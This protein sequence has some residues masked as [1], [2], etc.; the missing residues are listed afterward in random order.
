MNQL[1]NTI[2]AAVIFCQAPLPVIQSLFAPGWDLETKNKLN[3]DKTKKI[4]KSI[5]LRVYEITVLKIEVTFLV[6]VVTPD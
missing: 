4:I 5:L 6:T 2:K 3:G 1:I